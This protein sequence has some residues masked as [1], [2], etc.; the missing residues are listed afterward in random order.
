[1]LDMS[2]PFV[3]T[4]FVNAYNKCCNKRWEKWKVRIYICLGITKLQPSVTLTSGCISEDKF[5]LGLHTEL[6][7]W[8]ELCI[9]EGRTWF[10]KDEDLEGDNFATQ[11]HFLVYSSI[12]PECAAPTH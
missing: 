4:P 6:T 9:Y 10:L 8:G 2:L 1:M 5:C 12:F 7:V 11:K 3:N